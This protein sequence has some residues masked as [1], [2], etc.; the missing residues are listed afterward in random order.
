VL[1]ELP[2]E[3]GI[4][5]WRSVRDVLLWVDTPREDSQGL[6]G[7]L[8]PLCDQV[9]RLIAAAPV[10]ANDLQTFHDLVREPE[11]ADA[12]RVGKACHQVSEWAA[13]RGLIA[14]RETFA[15]AAAYVVPDNGEYALDAGL[16]AR[17]R[18]AFG[19]ADHWYR[20]GLSIARRD[21]DR[22]TYV[23]AL[24]RRGVLDEL[25]GNVD[26]ARALQTRAWRAARRYKLRKLAAYAQ[27]EL[28]VLSITT[29]EFVEAQVHAALACEL[30]GRLDDRFPQLAH[31]VAFMWAW[32]R[33][34]AA[35]LPVYEA[36]LPYVTNPGERI[37]L[38]ANIGRA[39]AASGNAEKFFEAWEQ[40]RIHADKA[41]EWRATALLSLAHGAATMGSHTQARQL[42][43]DALAIARRMSLVA[44][45]TQALQ[46]IAELQAGQGKDQNC[47]TPAELESIGA[48]LV[49]R[50]SRRRRDSRG[51]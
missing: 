1:D 13:E 28:L 9:L 43:T 8:P 2:E 36:V 37:Q 21:C 46:F 42:V 38:I 51:M 18:G 29:R 32:H 47:R 40:V 10:L 41:A 44:N 25:R 26:S 16:A 22:H 34:F 7:D 15:E 39:A 5:R 11:H 23:V 50:L 4:E 31:D 14:V 33:Y 20:R 6:F 27:H 12:R 48:E 24:I 17:H 35:A 3:L 19:R 30:Y 49:R 45:E